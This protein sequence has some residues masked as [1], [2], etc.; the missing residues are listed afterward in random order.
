MFTKSEMYRKE[1][2]NKKHIT[3]VNA[4]TF[5]YKCNE[6]RIIEVCG[7]M[8]E[9]LRLIHPTC[10]IEIVYI[11][12]KRTIEML[13]VHSTNFAYENPVQYKNAMKLFDLAI[14]TILDGSICQVVEGAI[15]PTC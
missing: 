3:K 5:D 4:Y 12:S 13:M 1:T 6:K 9:A 10:K 14:K 8:N 2:N 7:M 11:R 15:F